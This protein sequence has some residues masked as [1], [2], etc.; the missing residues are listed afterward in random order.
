MLNEEGEVCEEEL[1]APMLKR[2]KKLTA[3]EL[4]RVD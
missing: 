3:E 4:A 1:E 2:F